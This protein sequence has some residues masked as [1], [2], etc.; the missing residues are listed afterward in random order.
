MPKEKLLTAVA[1]NRE[2]KKLYR[3]LSKTRP[4]TDAKELARWVANSKAA[5]EAGKK[6]GFVVNSFDPHWNINSDLGSND[7]VSDWIMCK[8]VKLLNI[9]WIDDPQFNPIFFSVTERPDIYE[10]KIGNKVEHRS[11]FLED[12]KPTFDTYSFREKYLDSAV[13]I[14]DYKFAKGE[15]K[16]IVLTKNGQ[17]IQEIKI[18]PKKKTKTKV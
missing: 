8:I 2:Y 18:K 10:I 6:L 9:P 3:H 1:L 7:I 16:S 11:F 15:K 13:G 17:V 14:S 12:I 4:V 5:R